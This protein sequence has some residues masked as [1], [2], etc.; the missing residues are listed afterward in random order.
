MLSVSGMDS[1]MV[2]EDMVTPGKDPLAS[3]KATRVPAFTLYTGF[4]GLHPLSHHLFF[5][6]SHIGIDVTA[7]VVVV[8][9]VTYGLFSLHE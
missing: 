3:G 4:E 5:A 2:T 9:T 8:V 7:D 6:P 1:L